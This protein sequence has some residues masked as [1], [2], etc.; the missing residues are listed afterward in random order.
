[1][2]RKDYAD[3]AFET[4]AFMERE[5]KKGKLFVASLS[6]VDDRGIEGGYYLWDKDELKA[7][8]SDA[9][10]RAVFKA[11]GL[12]KPSPFEGG[13]L[14]IPQD[15][16]PASLV[17]SAQQKLLR[18][19]Q[20]R[21]LPRDEKA[22][23]SWNA[24]ALSA[25]RLATRQDPAWKEKAET[26]AGAI[27]ETFWDG[28]EL[29]RLRKK[30]VAVPGTLEDYAY[31]LDAFSGKAFGRNVPRGTWLKEAWSRFH[32]KGWFLSGE[33]LLPFAV[34]KPM[35]E[36]GAIPSPSA[37]LIRVTLETKGEL[38]QRAG[39]ALKDALPWIAAHPFSYATAIP[40][41]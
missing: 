36:D 18:A 15:E 33:R 8:L 11:W 24:L 6:A 32:R 9:E 39:E 31:V 16:A 23:A 34:P 1:Y 3:I 35:L 28:K 12:D 30:K 19:R 37:V 20:K 26:L 29:W 10:Y 4:L 13:Y 7:L 40:L 14:P 27:L 5:M 25:F 21:S 38:R 22:L 41:L 2:G 17:E